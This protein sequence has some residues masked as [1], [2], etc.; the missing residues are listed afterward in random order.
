MYTVT[1]NLFIS[2]NIIQLYNFDLKSELDQKPN[3][4]LEYDID[5]IERT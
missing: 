3:K 1:R 5:K 4:L 2:I